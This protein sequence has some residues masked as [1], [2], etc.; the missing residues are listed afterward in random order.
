MGRFA[1]PAIF[2]FFLLVATAI[3]QGQSFPGPSPNNNNNS[4]RSQAVMISNPIPVSEAKIL[5]NNSWVVLTGNVIN[6][7]PGGRQYTFRDNSGE[8]SVDIGPRQWRGLSIDAADKVEI[9]GELRILRGHT[10]VRVYAIRKI[11]E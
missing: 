5:P 3:A 1:F 9:Y 7:L 11:E 6:M 8:V 2:L 10:S 4:P